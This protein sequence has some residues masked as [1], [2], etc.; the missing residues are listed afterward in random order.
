[1]VRSVYHVM[2]IG[3]AWGVRR[4][5]R[6]RADSLHLIKTDAIARAKR[7]ARAAA[8]GQVKVHGRNGRIQNEF[9]YKED[10]RNSRG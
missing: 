7:L 10:P 2:P 4:E 3:D 6:K 9:T 8:V 1:M 5:R